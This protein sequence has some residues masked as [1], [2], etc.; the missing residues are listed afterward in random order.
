MDELLTLLVCPFEYAELL[1]DGDALRCVQ[2]QRRY[3]IDEDGIVSFLG[4]VEEGAAGWDTESERY[5][6]GFSRYTDDVE[7]PATVGR[8][9]SLPV[10]TV[11]DH[12]CGTGRMTAA[13]HRHTGHRVLALDYSRENLR[14]LLRDVEK[15]SVLAL[16]ADARRLPIRSGCL[17]GV[18][19]AGVYPL[20]RAD[21]RRVLIDELHRVLHPRGSLVLST[22]NYSWVFRLWRLR[23]NRGAREGDHLYGQDIYYRRQSGRELRRELNERFEVDTLCGIRNI[24]VR[25]LV[26]GCQ[27][28]LGERRSAPLIRLINRIGPGLDRAVERVMVSRLTGF[29]LLARARPRADRER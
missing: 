23:G 18:C 15:G 6:D 28:V 26:G 1:S 13:L 19:S 4:D 8:L 3:P 7:I 20:L 14:R 29:M 9:P 24:P 22:L 16:H 25:T 21:E 10:P 27:R 5:A 17:G 12:G 11:L 2:C